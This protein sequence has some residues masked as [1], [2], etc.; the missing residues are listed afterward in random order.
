VVVVV[1]VVVVV[2]VIVVVMVVVVV[3]EVS[4]ESMAGLIVGCFSIHRN[5]RAGLGSIS[6]SSDIIERSVCGSGGFW[7]VSDC[8]K[9]IILINIYLI[10]CCLVHFYCSCLFVAVVLIN[11]LP[12]LTVLFFLVSLCK[13]RTQIYNCSSY[14]S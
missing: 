4:G 11:L 1:I 10:S 6:Y 8:S 14:L 9:F 5:V 3:V 7:E 2:V 12:N 13:V